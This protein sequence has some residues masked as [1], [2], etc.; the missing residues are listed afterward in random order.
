MGIFSG[1]VPSNSAP[2]QAEPFVAPDISGMTDR[3][4]AEAT[5]LTML[6]SE[7]LIRQVMIAAQSNPLLSS[8]VP[9]P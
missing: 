2:M 5:Y 6:K 4:I 7:H 8:M 3:E 1:L 9:R